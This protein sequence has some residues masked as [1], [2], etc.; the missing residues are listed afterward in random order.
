MPASTPQEMMDTFF[1]R[2]CAHDIEAVLAL[3]EPNAVF[4]DEPGKVVQG[5]DAIR[6]SLTTFMA[7]KPNLKLVKHET[8]ASGDIETNFVKWTLTGTGSD[9]EPISMEGAAVDVIRRQP[10]GTRKFVIDNPWGVAILD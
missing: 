9:D 8:L 7:M 6:E 3:Y 5:T 4:V 2:F 10:D 1:E